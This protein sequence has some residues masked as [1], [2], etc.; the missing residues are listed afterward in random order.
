MKTVLMLALIAGVL[1]C[2]RKTEIRP[3]ELVAP[4][5]VS[6]LA[7]DSTAEGVRLRWTRPTETVDGKS[8][9]DLAGFVIERAVTTT[10]R[11]IARVPV[12]DRGRFQKAKRFEYLDRD[13]VAD[14]IFHYRVI[15]YTTDGYYSAPTGAATITWT[16]TAVHAAESPTPEP[17]PVPEPTR[18]K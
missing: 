8:M 11:E 3:P 18:L 10:F 16:P 2:G 7:L 5:A 14:M 15:A 4:K 12:T 9:E 6:Q 13:V 1:S 17:T